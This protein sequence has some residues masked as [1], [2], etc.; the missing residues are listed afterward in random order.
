MAS[1]NELLEHAASLG[2]DGTTIPND[3][4][5]EQKIL[6]LLKNRTAF[7]GTSG[8]GVLTSDNTNVSDGDTVTI[9]TQTYTFKTA[10]TSPDTAYEVLIGASADAS[11]LNL[12]RC[13]NMSGGTAG[14][15]YAATTPKNKWVTCSTTVS[16]HTITVTV[17]D[18]AVTNAS[19]ATTETS[20]HLS[21]GAATI[22]SGVAKVI[23]PGTSTVAGA[24]GLSGDK[25]VSV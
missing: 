5:L 22:A 8:T 14:T 12:A 1:R 25:N 19:V 7:T 24:P 3:S 20:S 10:L 17:A 11:L 18:P 4:K 15:D 23:A 2:F 16:S 9:G 13:I 6:Y 21:W